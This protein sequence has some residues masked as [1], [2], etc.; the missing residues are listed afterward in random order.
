M[1]QVTK[2]TLVKIVRTNLDESGVNDSM[3]LGGSDDAMLDD[4]IWNVA[5][6]CADEIHSAAPV[7]MLDGESLLAEGSDYDTSQITVGESNAKVLHVPIKNVIRLVA[8]KAK[9]SDYVVTE[10][11]PEASPEGRMQLDPNLC[12]IYDDP[13][14]VMQQGSS[15]EDATMIYYS[16]KAE[17][18][19]D[20]SSVAMVEKLSVIFRQFGKTD[21]VKVADNVASNFYNLVT[22]KVLTI[23][24]DQRAQ[25]YYNKAKFV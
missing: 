6:E 18:G 19:K 22:A 24:G 3:M 15:D 7:Q 10:T 21:S 8:F 25:D 5:G 1:K 9:D 12:G 4:I 17:L 11:I 14:V 20:E 2:S 13:K 23:M 16:L